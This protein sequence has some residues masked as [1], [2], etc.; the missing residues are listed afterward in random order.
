MNMQSMEKDLIIFGLKHSGK[1]S[2][3]RALAPF[4]G[5]QMFDIDDLLAGMAVQ[6]HPELAEGESGYAA[7]VRK[8]F[9]THGKAA[10][11]EYET[12]VAE[13]LCSGSRQQRRIIATGGGTMENGLA[14][15]HLASFGL[16]IFINAPEA[17]L[18]TR[19]MKGGIPAFLNPEDPQ[20]SFHEVYTRRTALMADY[21]DITVDVSDESLE[22]VIAL[23]L[24]KIKEYDHGR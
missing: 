15:D 14:M 20:G 13:F 2:I 4:L 22:T 21:A 1:S 10:F 16:C 9:R 7:I 12:R 5:V 24:R 6:E 19:I 18:F 17:T 11:Q 3:A 23:V 8:L